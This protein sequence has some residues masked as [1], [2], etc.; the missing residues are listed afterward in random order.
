MAVLA[1]QTCFSADS[2][3]A[4]L[5]VSLL[6]RGSDLPRRGDLG[7]AA[8]RWSSRSPSEVQ[9]HRC[10]E[11]VPEC[12]S[13]SE[14]LAA[15]TPIGSVKMNWHVFAACDGQP[16]LIVGSGA[17]VDCRSQQASSSLRAE[18]RNAAIAVG[19]V[20]SRGL[21]RVA[22]QAGRSQTDRRRRWQEVRVTQLR[23]L[24][25]TSRG[26]DSEESL[27]ARPHDARDP[28]HVGHR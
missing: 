2:I 11:I 7:G 27:L 4:A 10:G 1:G 25:R 17:R 3:S 15:T 22:R 21:R 14:S 18:V 20:A 19:V 24:G 26:G 5:C 12:R 8:S 9:L 23:R 16:Y 6:D 13:Q 28:Q